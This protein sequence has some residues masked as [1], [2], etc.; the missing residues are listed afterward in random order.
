MW[1]A[2]NVDYSVTKRDGRSRKDFGNDDKSW[3]LDPRVKK[4]YQVSNEQFYGPA[5]RVDRGH[6]IRREDNCWGNTP[7]EI[8]Y[9]NADSFHWTNCTPQHQAFNQSGL[10]GL[11]G[12][13]EDHIKESLN[14]VNNKASIFAGPVLD[15]KNDPKIDFGSGD[16]QYP[17]KFWKI[18]IAVDQH[19]GLM[20]YGFVIDQ[21]DVILKFGLEPIDFIKFKTQQMNLQAITQMTGVHF[22]DILYKSDVLKPNAVMAGVESRQILT[23]QDVQLHPYKDRGLAV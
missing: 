21:S 5:K 4:D 7:L 10:N 6:M 17:L 12:K 9:A 1:S 19:E 3:R 22:P 8:E 15:N 2:V 13:L 11:W 20:A 23:L 16:V 14:L 18:L